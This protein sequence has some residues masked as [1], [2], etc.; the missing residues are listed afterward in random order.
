MIEK[1]FAK[2]NDTQSYYISLE[3]LSGLKIKDAL[4]YVTTEFGDAEFKVSLLILEDNDGKEIKI[5]L[6][7][8]H[9]IAYLGMSSDPVPNLDSDFLQSLYDEENPS[10]EEETKELDEN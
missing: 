8:E 7:G 6:E 3:K 10:E 1:F 9:D 2:E 4:G 5:W